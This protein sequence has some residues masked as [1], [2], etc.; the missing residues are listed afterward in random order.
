MRAMRR[1]YFQQQGWPHRLEGAVR[2]VVLHTRLQRFPFRYWTSYNA[3][4][5]AVGMLLGG[6]D[7]QAS[8]LSRLG[9]KAGEGAAGVNAGLEDIA[10]VEPWTTSFNPGTTT[11]ERL[12]ELTP[13]VDFAAFLFAV[14]TGRPIAH[15]HPISRD[16]ARLRR[17]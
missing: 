15:P 17:E 1:K 5:S 6:M 9:G 4:T 13:E 3:V 14:T 8:H 12:L 10:H 16:P 2:R 7:G 11:L